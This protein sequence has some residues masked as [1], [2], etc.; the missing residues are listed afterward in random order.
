MAHRTQAELLGFI[1]AS[2]GKDREA[3]IDAVGE[4]SALVRETREQLGR[5]A[6]LKG[7]PLKV[8][9]TADSEAL[10]LACLFSEYWYS[11]LADAQIGREK[12]RATALYRAVYRFRMERFGPTALEA[13][14]ARMRSVPVQDILHGKKT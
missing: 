4:D 1:L 7:L 8:A 14:M 13:E 3:F 12:I 5:I 2:A 10:R 11:S 9:L 6:A